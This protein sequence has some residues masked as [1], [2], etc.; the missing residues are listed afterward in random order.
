MVSY[1][2][3]VFK[4]EI[5]IVQVKE[6]SYFVR[7]LNVS[8]NPVY[9]IFV[10]IIEGTNNIRNGKKSNVD[11]GYRCY[12]TNMFK[13]HKQMINVNQFD[14]HITQPICLIEYKTT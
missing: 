6:I 10:Y 3:I 5:T 11:R 2:S 7:R 4:N 13:M 8:I 9:F 12:S 14:R 1:R